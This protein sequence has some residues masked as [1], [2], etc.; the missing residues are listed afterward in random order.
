MVETMRLTETSHPAGRPRKAE[1]PEGVALEL[2]EIIYAG[3]LV[4]PSREE[5]LSTYS[6]C[7]RTVRSVPSGGAARKRTA[8]PMEDELSASRPTAPEKAAALRRLS[9]EAV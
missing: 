2:L 3:E 8:S 5:I 7:L 4:K 6:E 9:E 1:T